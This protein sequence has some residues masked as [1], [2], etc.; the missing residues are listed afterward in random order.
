MLGTLGHSGLSRMTRVTENAGPIANWCPGGTKR[1]D[2][3]TL[4][5]QSKNKSTI[6]ACTRTNDSITKIVFKGTFLEGDLS[7]VYKAT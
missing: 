6:T 3:L 2:W 5:R 7:Y 1:T 4:S